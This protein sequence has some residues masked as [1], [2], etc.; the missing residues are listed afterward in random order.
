MLFFPATST[1]WTQTLDSELDPD[2]LENLDSEELG[3]KKGWKTT[4]YNLSTLK[5]C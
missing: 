1:T 3:W 5:I 4:E 2:P